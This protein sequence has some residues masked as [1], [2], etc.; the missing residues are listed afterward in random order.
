MFGTPRIWRGALW[1]SIGLAWFLLAAFEGPTAMRIVPGATFLAV[2]IAYCV[3]A[4]QD[5]T[6]KRGSYQTLTAHRTHDDGSDRD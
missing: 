4:L 2:G 1:C 3:V 5:R 6:H